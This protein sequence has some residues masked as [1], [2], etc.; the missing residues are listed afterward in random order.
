MKKDTSRRKPTYEVDPQKRA[1]N[2]AYNSL[3]MTEKSIYSFLLDMCW[4][5]E[6]QYMIDIDEDKWA[7]ILQVD[8]SII[9]SFIFAV[10]KEVDGFLL[11]EETFNLETS[12]F[13][14]IILDLKEQVENYNAWAI[15]EE[16]LTRKKNALERKSV[17]LL[18]IAKDRSEALMGVVH[19]VEPENRY[20][21]EYL[22]WFPTIGFNE[23]GQVYR[24]RDFVINQL[25][26]MYPDLNIED[27]I[28]KMF[29]WFSNPK[30]RRR[31]VAQMNYFIHNWLER[32]SNG[33]ED[34]SKDDFNLDDEINKLIDFEI[35]KA[36]NE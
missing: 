34:K 1:L 3:S 35:G 32:A 25:S 26:D 9:K 7:S 10:T 28:K 11:A 6:S 21:N 12:T 15:K 24:I 8:V 13:Q 17:K 2:K 20:L 29:F 33:W 4:V 30:N 16:E 27:E 31:T 18:D 14:L 5:G 36:V 19:Y 23:T 22:G